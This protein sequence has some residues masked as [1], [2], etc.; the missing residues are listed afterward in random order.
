MSQF[1]DATQVADD[2]STAIHD[3]WDI[4]GNANGGY[5]MA[6]A[7]AGLRWGEMPT[8]WDVDQPA[9]VDRAA[10]LDLL[11]CRAPGH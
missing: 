4:G 2:G 8:L 10:A 1:D 7:A 6:L 9:D 5:L 3:G 11:R